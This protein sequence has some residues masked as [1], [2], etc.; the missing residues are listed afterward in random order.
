MIA[1]LKTLA[2]AQVSGKRIAVLGD[3]KELGES[4]ATEHARVGKE[5]SKL[6]I[7]YILTLGEQAKHIHNS[8]STANRI[9]YEQKNMLAEYLAELV[10]PGDAV[11]VK[12]SRGM[13]MEDVV[14]FLQERLTAAHARG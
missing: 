6:P 7:D 1:A 8:T 5:L 14:A 11:L 10:S 2:A 13:K 4:S 12:G 3:M 9:H